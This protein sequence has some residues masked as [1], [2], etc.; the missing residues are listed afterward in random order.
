MKRIL[1]FILLFVLS[2]CSSN[3]VFTSR[4]E[5][6][7]FTGCAT[8]ESRYGE[9]YEGCFDKGKM[10]GFGA[11]SYPDGTVYKGPFYNDF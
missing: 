7:D 3:P 2:A 10:Q 9:R 8:Y 1:V 4:N 5:V 11:Y 6:A